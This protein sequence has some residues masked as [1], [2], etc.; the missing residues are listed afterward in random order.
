MDTS[1]FQKKIICCDC[2]VEGDRRSWNQRRCN[3]CAVAADKCQTKAHTKR[4]RRLTRTTGVH[5][6]RC[7]RPTGKPGICER[8]AAYVSAWK[9]ANKERVNAINQGRRG[10][11]KLSKGLAERLLKLQRGRCVYCKAGLAGGYHLD[12]VMPLFLGGTN[13]DS[14]IQL[15]CPTCNQSK[16]AKHPTE[17]AKKHGL[18]L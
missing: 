2:G 4:W 15:L 17:Y 10:G 9:R 5:C 13:E 3:P 12:H 16:G 11:G 7:A 6:S 1:L 14:N 8:C 18:L